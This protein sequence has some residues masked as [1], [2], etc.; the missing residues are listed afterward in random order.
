M[1][2]YL[3]EQG[4]FELDG[5]PNKRIADPKMVYGMMAVIGGG[6]FLGYAALVSVERRF[7]YALLDI[8]QRYESGKDIE[9]QLHNLVDE[10]VLNHREEDSRS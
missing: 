9:K 4:R 3:I 8:T 2:G 7:E 6:V 5:D 1:L 10:A